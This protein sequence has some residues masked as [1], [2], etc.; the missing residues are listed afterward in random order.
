M[1]K[2]LLEILISGQLINWWT[3]TTDQAFDDKKECFIDLFDSFEIEEVEMNVNGRLT[4][5]ENIAD[6]GGIRSSHLTYGKWIL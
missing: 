4:L 3:N 6:F 2:A 5:G 1:P